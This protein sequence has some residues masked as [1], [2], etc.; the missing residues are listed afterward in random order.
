MRNIEFISYDGVWPRLCGGTLTL[1]IDGE[2]WARKNVLFSGGA[3]NNSR[4]PAELDIS[5]GP[6]IL[7]YRMAAEF[8]PEEMEHIAALIN[9]R[10]PYGCCGRCL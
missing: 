7:D 4:D 9:E 8:S 3:V 10:I 6:W 5:Y 2:E 1:R